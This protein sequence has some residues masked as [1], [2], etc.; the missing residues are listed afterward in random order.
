MN[1]ED[2]KAILKAVLDNVGQSEGTIGIRQTSDLDVPH[3]VFKQ[4]LTEEQRAALKAFL[5]EEQYVSE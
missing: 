4:D 1:V 3:F 2:W 5:L